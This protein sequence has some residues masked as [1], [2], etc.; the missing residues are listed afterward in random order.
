MNTETCDHVKNLALVT[1]FVFQK[2]KITTKQWNFK[3]NILEADL[4]QYFVND[5]DRNTVHIS[6]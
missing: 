4:S 1:V 5:A 6:F 3:V 2:I